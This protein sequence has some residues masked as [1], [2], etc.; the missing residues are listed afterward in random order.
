MTIDLLAHETND[1]GDKTVRTAANRFLVGL[2]EAHPQP[3]G[4]LKPNNEAQDF[5]RGCC[6][7]SWRSSRNSLYSVNE[8]ALLTE[9]QNALERISSGKIRT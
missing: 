5:R 4:A 6:V 8:Q 2:T 9:V 7:D 1:F 3:V